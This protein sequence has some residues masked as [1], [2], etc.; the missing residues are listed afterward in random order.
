M[1]Q[2]YEG[3][4]CLCMAIQCSRRSEYIEMDCEDK[5]M[6]DALY[7]V[8]D[9]YRLCLTWIVKKISLNLR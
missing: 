3:V 5:D 1:I 6:S 9:K 8:N 4:L 2:V 7:I